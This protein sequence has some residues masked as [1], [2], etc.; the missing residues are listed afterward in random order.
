[1]GKGYRD[2][3][4]TSLF[5]L[6]SNSPSG[7]LR[8]DEFLFSF[9]FKNQTYHQSVKQFGSRSRTSIS[10]SKLFARVK[11]SGWLMPTSHLSIFTYFES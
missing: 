5:I 2:Y 11:Y 8:S 4:G 7:V 9:F 6:V 3:V 1:M 10:D